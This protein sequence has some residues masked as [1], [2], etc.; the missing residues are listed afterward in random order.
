MRVSSGNYMPVVAAPLGLWLD[1]V[2]ADIPLEEAMEREAGCTQCGN[3]LKGLISSS[4]FEHTALA[5]GM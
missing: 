3:M 1:L 2:E 5:A 4:T